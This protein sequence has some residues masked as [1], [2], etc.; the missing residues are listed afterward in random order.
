MAKIV[1]PPSIIRVIQ[2]PETW[3]PTVFESLI[4]NDLENSSGPLAASD[5][6]LVALLV[7]TMDSL[8]E[9]HV[10]ILSAGPTYMYNSGEATSAWQKIRMEC[11]D[12]ILK[13]MTELSLATRSRAKTQAKPT[14]VDELFASA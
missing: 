10:K 7:M 4:R 5:E 14:S 6:L 2:N 1:P 13:L 9:A 12:K 11:L 8:V 3:N